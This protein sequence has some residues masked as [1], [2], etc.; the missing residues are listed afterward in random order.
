MTIPHEKQT[1]EWLEQRLQ[2]V[3]QKMQ[4]L[5]PHKK[6]RQQTY[7]NYLNSILGN[8]LRPLSLDF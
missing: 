7:V 1:T 8:R 3:L 5:R 6:E 4:G 2:E